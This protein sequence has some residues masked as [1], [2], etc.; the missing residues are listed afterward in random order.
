MDF[1]ELI[2]KM[3]MLIV[4]MLI[5]YVGARRGVFGGAFAKGLSSLVMNLFLTCSILDSVISGPQDISG[6][7]LG[8]VMLVLSLVMIL[9]YVIAIASVRLMHLNDENGPV[10][11]LSMCVV[12]SMFVGLPVV[13]EMFGSTAVLY[14]ALSCIP[15]NVIL[16]TYGIWRMKKGKN[17]GGGSAVQLRDIVTVPLLATVAALVIFIFGIP[18]PRLVREFISLTAPATVS[19]SMIVIGATLGSVKL[20]DA[21]REKRIYLLC[22]IKLIVCPLAVWLLLHFLTA[23][24]VLL[25]TGVIVAACPTGIVVTVLALQY[26]YDAA[27]SSKGVLATVVLSMITLPVFAYFLM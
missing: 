23:D 20:S 14:C 17:I 11:E 25:A 12:N 24:P 8:H 2:I 1:S 3:T 7:G 5:G 6:A 19:T 27:Y 21:F 10:T 9:M 22:F 18:M 15:F 4:L 13:Q 16:Y 26:D